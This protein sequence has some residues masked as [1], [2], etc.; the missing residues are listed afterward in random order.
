VL[1]F[2]RSAALYRLYAVLAVTRLSQEGWELL[3]EVWIN[4]WAADDPLLVVL[5]K[6]RMGTQRVCGNACPIETSSHIAI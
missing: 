6:W 1:E 4:L 2:Q 3:S 5:L